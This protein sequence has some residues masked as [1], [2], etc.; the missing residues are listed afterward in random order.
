MPQALASTGGAAEGCV[1][2]SCLVSDLSFAWR[3]RPAGQDSG[4][5]T[6]I[7]VHVEIPDAEAHRLDAQREVIRRSLQNLA[8]LAS[9]MGL[10]PPTPPGAR[11]P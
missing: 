11:R 8:A 4:D 10:R 9:V 5:G 1:T 3:L 2:I 7:S 6:E